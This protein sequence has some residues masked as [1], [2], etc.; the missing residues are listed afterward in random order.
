LQGVSVEYGQMKKATLNIE[1]L[2]GDKT[3]YRLSKDTGIDYKTI[4]SHVKGK[5]SSVRLDHIALLCEALQCSPAELIT[6]TE[7]K[8]K[9][10]AKK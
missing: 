6:I 3:L 5:T 10:K 1:S 2:L 7:D 8:P 4:H 9:R